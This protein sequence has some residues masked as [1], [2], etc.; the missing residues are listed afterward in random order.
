[1]PSCAA[2]A[3]GRVQHVQKVLKRKLLTTALF[4]IQGQLFRFM[5]DIEQRWRRAGGP[6]LRF[7]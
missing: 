3:S 1:M 2:V 7:A 6:D 4:V 5:M